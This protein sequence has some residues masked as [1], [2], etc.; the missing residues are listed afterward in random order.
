MKHIKL[1]ENYTV[2]KIL[3]KINSKGIESLSNDEKKYL[4]FH[5]KDSLN[6]DENYD[7]EEIEDKISKQF[8]HDKLI[9][10]LKNNH[11][12]DDDIAD[13][14]INYEDD[15]IELYSVLIM[16]TDDLNKKTKKMINNYFMD[17]YIKIR[18]DG[19]KLIFVFEDYGEEIDEK[20]REYVF[21]YLLD[22]ELEYDIN[23]FIF[24]QFV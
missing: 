10:A 2:D 7:K 11:I 4:D 15:F 23:E 1:F 20:E 24:P 6:D 17:N 21:D 14:R 19:D 16:P 13:D 12:I 8:I 18:L 3:D 9:T 22:R 5:S